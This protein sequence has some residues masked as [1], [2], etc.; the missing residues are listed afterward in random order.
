MGAGRCRCCGGGKS[1]SGWRWNPLMLVHTG[2]CFNWMGTQGKGF[3]TSPQSARSP[4]D[5]AQSLLATARSPG[6]PYRIAPA[7]ALGS[8]RWGVRRWDAAPVAAAARAF[9]RS[10]TSQGRV[11]PRALCA[12]GEFPRKPSAPRWGRP[13]RGSPPARGSG[14]P[15]EP[16]GLEAFSGNPLSRRVAGKQPLR[17][18]ATDT[19]P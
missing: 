1:V 13:T 2:G 11:H 15:W 16:P 5:P 3:K 7:Q 6:T 10:L 14:K 4:E 8:G 9:L 12:P 18:H 19:P 17:S